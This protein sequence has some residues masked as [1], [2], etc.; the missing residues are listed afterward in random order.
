MTI[1]CGNGG[2]DWSDLISSQGPSEPGR[3]KEDAWGFE[4][5]HSADT[6]VAGLTLNWEGIYFCLN[7]VGLVITGPGGHHISMRNMEGTC[8]IEQEMA[9]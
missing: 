6:S 8:T 1:P 9:R 3:T 7:H 4:E 5:R 2:R